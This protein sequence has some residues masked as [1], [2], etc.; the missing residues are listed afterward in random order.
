MYVSAAMRP[1]SVQ[2]GSSKQSKVSKVAVKAVI[3][4]KNSKIV[5]GDAARKLNKV[6][7]PI[8]HAAGK[9]AQSEETMCEMWPH[10][11]PN[12]NASHAS[13]EDASNLQN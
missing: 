4:Y 12:V 13:L 6:T 1:K 2:I 5:Q 10:T 11:R 9:K 7:K 3:K 8:F